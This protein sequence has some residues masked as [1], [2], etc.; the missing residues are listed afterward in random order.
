MK[1]FTLFGKQYFFTHIFD[2]IVRYD[3]GCITRHENENLEIITTD[4]RTY[5]HKIFLGF[6]KKSDS[7]IN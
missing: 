2:R 1:K 6:Y 5:W 7:W 3:F 4:T